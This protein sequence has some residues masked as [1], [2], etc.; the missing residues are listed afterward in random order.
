ML[1]RRL[2]GRCDASFPQHSGVVLIALMQDLVE[3]LLSALRVAAEV[4]LATGNGA[5]LAPVAALFVLSR[6][7]HS[8]TYRPLL[9]KLIL[10][11]MDVSEGA[12]IRSGILNAVRACYP[13]ELA[14]SALY[15]L[16]VLASNRFADDAALGA[17]PLRERK[18]T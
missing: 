15:L 14:A 1:C 11:L 16:S 7:C 13:R 17:L 4:E 2:F 10:A 8:L 6:L 5:A 12:K 9:K 3:P 18:V